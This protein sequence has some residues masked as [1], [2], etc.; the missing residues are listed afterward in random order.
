MKHFYFE[1]DVIKQILH[2]HGG[3]LSTIASILFLTLLA[4]I[5]VVPVVWLAEYG[6][7]S[8]ALFYFLAT[9]VTF[10]FTIVYYDARSKLNE[11]AKDSIKGR[12]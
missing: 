5:W 12:L 7:T 11:K 2:D 1:S 6:Y 3:A 8:N 9:P 4:A 10:V